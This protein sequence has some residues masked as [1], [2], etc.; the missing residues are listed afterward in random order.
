MKTYVKGGRENENEVG[1]S[2]IRK[3]KE[4]YKGWQREVLKSE[5]EKFERI[6]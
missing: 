4:L 6:I 5:W 3:R 1:V 2:A